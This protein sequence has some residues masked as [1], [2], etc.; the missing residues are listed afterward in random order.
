[1]SKVVAWVLDESRVAAGDVVNLPDVPGLWMAGEPKTAA[2]LGLDVS[3][4]RSLV[5]ELDLPLKETKA[6]EVDVDVVTG[7][8]LPSAPETRLVRSDSPAP[9]L[10]ADEYAAREKWDAEVAENPPEAVL[11]EIP[12]G[13]ETT[14]T[15]DVA[16]E[17]QE[18]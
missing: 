16:G 4:M 10:D 11:A 7:A 13:A 9:G 17:G 14:T 1:M 3:A 15:A 12:A 8:D 5:R 6:D 18:G 2:E